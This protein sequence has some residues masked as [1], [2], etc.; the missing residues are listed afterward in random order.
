MGVS[1]RGEAEA[2]ADLAAFGRPF[3]MDQLGPALRDIA[4]DG[5]EASTQ[6]QTT[7]DGAPWAPL[8]DDYRKWKQA[9]AP[10]MPIGILFGVMLARPELDGVLLT[11]HERAEHSYGITIAARVE[12]IKFTLGGIVTG[13]NQPERPF[14]GLTHQAVAR[15]NDLCDAVFVRATT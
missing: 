9:V 11:N 14:W 2:L 12:A 4:V 3:D 13:T 5:M 10:G 8:S 6:A 1:I 7:P 15:M